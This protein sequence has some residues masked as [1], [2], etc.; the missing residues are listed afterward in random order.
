M[1]VFVRGKEH[2]EAACRFPAK[3]SRFGCAA[4]SN[5]FFRGIV[6]G[7]VPLGVCIYV[8]RRTIVI[9]SLL[10]VSLSSSGC[11]NGDVSQHNILTASN[12]SD[13]EGSERWNI[14]L[15]CGDCGKFS[16]GRSAREF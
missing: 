14:D 4:Q 7:F 15:K 5:G 2:R 8:M 13:E 3:F 16:I 11:E 12:Y 9:L 1:R 6:E 10:F